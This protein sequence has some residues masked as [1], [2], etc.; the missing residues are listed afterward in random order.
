[1]LPLAFSYAPFKSTSDASRL[2]PTETPRVVDL[3]ASPMTD[4]E[5][6][7]V[8]LVASGLS[9]KQIAQEL[10]LSVHTVHTHRKNI[11][12]KTQLP[13]INAVIRWASKKHLI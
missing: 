11:L 10:N 2:K 1:M 13:N 3:N 4:R 12:K 7:V 6:E 9:S 5:Q 8:R